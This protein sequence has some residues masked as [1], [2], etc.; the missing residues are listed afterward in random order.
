M[1]VCPSL[2]PLLVASA[3][4]HSYHAQT[5]GELSHPG[6]RSAGRLLI[7]DPSPDHRVDTGPKLGSQNL[8]L[9][10]LNFELRQIQRFIS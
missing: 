6:A 9:G 2:L 3:R 10:N 7:T 1:F 4:P 8:F 5:L